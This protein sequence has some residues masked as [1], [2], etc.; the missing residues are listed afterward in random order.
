MRYFLG[1][2]IAAPAGL[3]VPGAEPCKSVLDGDYQ[4]F[5]DFRW[6]PAKLSDNNPQQEFGEQ[7]RMNP[8]TTSRLLTIVGFVVLAVGLISTAITS[9]PSGPPPP[10]S[11]VVAT[12]G[13]R[14]ITLREVEQAVA[15]PLSQMEQQRMQLLQQGVQRIVDEELLASEASRKGLSVTQLVDDASQSE[16]IARLADIPAPVRQV[17]GQPGQARAAAPDLQQQARIRQAILVSL[18]RKADIHV[19]LPAP[20]LPILVVDSDDDPGIG[21]ETA[22]ITIVEFSDFQC[23]Y[24]QRS[25]SVLKEL[26]R[27]YG[28]KIRVVYR[29]YPGPNHP[30][31]AAAA[32]AAQCAGGQGK[33]WEYHDALFERQTAGKGWDFLALATDLGLQREA[34]DSCLKS[35]RFREE[36]TKD[37]QDGLKLGIT[38]TPTF[39]INGRPMVGAQPLAAF[40]TIIDNLLSQQVHS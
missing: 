29:D 37:L 38:S 30:L 27:I 6:L 12:V 5:M 32:E 31:A 34:F 17:A 4:E 24:C 16:T 28:D 2:N 18:R 36:V 3:V 19:T 10:A 1:G 22:P 13:S 20:A 11:P 23:P 15:L 9:R 35:G 40:Q 21:P 39:F 14:T 33:F 7:F 8:I 25:V 26:R